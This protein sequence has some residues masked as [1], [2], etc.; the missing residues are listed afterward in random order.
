MEEKNEDEEKLTLVAHVV[1]R[2][3]EGGF[4]VVREIRAAKCQKNA[5]INDRVNEKRRE[6]RGENVPEDH[7]RD[8]KQNLKDG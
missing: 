6:E 2:S 5:N 3:T 8:G 7:T 1:L 4:I